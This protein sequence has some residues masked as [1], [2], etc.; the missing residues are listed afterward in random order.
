MTEQKSVRVDFS[1][2]AQKNQSILES[3]PE[4]ARDYF[5]K[6]ESYCNFDLP[7]YFDFAPLLLRLNEGLV[8]KKLCDFKKNHPKGYDNLNYTILNNKDGGY[9]WRPLQLIHPALYVLLVRQITVE[10]NWKDICTRFKKF[11]K[12]KEIECISI[13]EKS[14]TKESNKAEQVSNWWQK[15]EQRSLEVALDYKYLTQ[16]DITDCYGAIYTHSVAWALH[17]KGDMKKKTINEKKLLIGD[18]IDEHL[19]SMSYGQTNGIPQGSALMDFIA[20]MVLGY[21]DSLLLKKI[22]KEKEIGKYQ[23]LRYR[24]D[25]RIFT[26]NPRDGKCILKCLTEVLIGLGLKLSA[27]KTKSSS[28]I[29]TSSIKSD[30]LYCME[31]KQTGFN[32]QKHLLIIHGLAKKYPN[33]GSLNISLHNFY[34]RLDGIKNFKDNIFPLISIVVD[35]AYNNPRIYPYFAAIISFLL[36]KI[37]C[38]DEKKEILEKIIYKFKDIPNTAHLPIW[39]QRIA[40]RII[41][42]MDFDANI[43]QIVLDKDK[44]LWNNSWLTEDMKNQIETTPIIDRAIIAKLGPVISKEEVELF[45][46]N[47]DGGY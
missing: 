46:S 35:I 44:N 20:E 36:N 41:V 9:A 24:D 10:D 39:L 6:S 31:Q 43:C 13:P 28:D 14:L 15:I 27:E 5:L 2:I 21:A 45:K 40:I 7:S 37:S 29:I 1:K 8:D 3:T 16:T 47:Y 23:I 19:R 32:L 4:E 22:L 11:A 30:K 42:Q 33:S 17:D 12:N 34:L 38:K 25:Y 26:N 18:I